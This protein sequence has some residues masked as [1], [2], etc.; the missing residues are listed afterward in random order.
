MISHPYFG[1]NFCLVYLR[2]HLQLILSTISMKKIIV[3]RGGP[4]D[5]GPLDKDEF[6][7]NDRRSSTMGPP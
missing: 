5:E 1:G 2:P 6:A 7:L 3:I 4:G